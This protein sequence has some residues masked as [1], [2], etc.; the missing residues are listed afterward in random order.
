MKHADQDFGGLL[1]SYDRERRPVGERVAKTSLY[2]M[3]AH[4]LVLDEAIGL[5]PTQ[6]EAENIQAMDEYFDISDEDQGLAKRQEVEKA[7]KD[8]DIEFYAH[9][10]EVG[11]YYDFSYH[12]TYGDSE[13]EGANPQ[14][15]S[16]GE[17]ELCTYHPNLRPGSQLP[18]AY[19]TGKTNG[20][21]ISTRELIV[22][23]K[24]ILL[25]MSADW[26]KIMHPY[27]E[28]RVVDEHNGDFIDVEGAWKRICS[29]LEQPGALVVRSDTIIAY[30]FL[31]DNILQAA[32]AEVQFGSIVETILKLG[33]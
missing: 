28:V 33:S 24:L 18:H 3:R 26:R 11:W 22:K 9:G 8:L 13:D 27:V 4:A 14:L 32:D 6:S 17:M 7:M 5:S 19:L 10:A 23:D 30:R 2:N 15:R 20:K 31:N 25:A 29:D 1:D 12:S 21:R 16:D